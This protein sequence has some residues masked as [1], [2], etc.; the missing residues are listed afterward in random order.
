M[1]REQTTLRLS[2]E[3]KEELQKEASQKGMS[4]NAW[5]LCLIYKGRQCQQK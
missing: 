1:E 4:F 3:L 5:V 2:P